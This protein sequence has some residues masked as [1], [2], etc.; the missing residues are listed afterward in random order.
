MA[1]AI[2][3]IYRDGTTMMGRAKING[4]NT[5]SKFFPVRIGNS[6]VFR[7]KNSS[8]QVVYG[9][10]FRDGSVMRFRTIA[11]GAPAFSCDPSCFITLPMSYQAVVTVSNPALFPAGTA[12]THTL[13]RQFNTQGFWQKSI[14]T[15]WSIF[16]TCTSLPN[17]GSWFEGQFVQPGL[18]NNAQSTQRVTICDPRG[19]YTMTYQML[20]E[21][22]K[23][24]TMVVS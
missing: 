22:P 18:F 2:G 10:P 1:V 3:Q 24:V 6:L 21:P 11:G 9:F 20:F 14:A 8:G 4:D 23:T 12:G 15:G 16:V 19:T 13:T 17:Q 7:G 5:I